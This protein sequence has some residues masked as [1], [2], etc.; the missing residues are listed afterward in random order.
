VT[1]NIVDITFTDVK[2]LEVVGSTQFVA[3]IAGTLEVD[4]TAGTVTNCALTASGTGF[5]TTSFT[6]ATLVAQSFGQF[7]VN[8]TSGINNTL[9]FTYTRFQ[10]DNLFF[11]ELTLGSFSPSFVGPPFLDNTLTSTP[12]PCF[13]EGALIRTPR[14][15]VPVETLKVGDL[16]VTG[17][18][19]LR[20][21]KW[22]GHRKVNCRAHPDPRPSA[23]SRARRSRRKGSYPDAS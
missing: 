9:K 5:I 8:A 22:L 3:S 13:V 19:A 10:P 15:D 20:P 7:T 2:I 12:V 11:L 14:G 23:S 17:S 6:T 16:V 21:V 18:G 1:D 4:Y